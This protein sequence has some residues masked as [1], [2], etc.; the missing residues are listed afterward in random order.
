MLDSCSCRLT[1]TV[2]EV[3]RLILHD[4]AYAR[5][6]SEQRLRVDALTRTLLRAFVAGLGAV[7]PA[8]PVRPAAVD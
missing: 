6:A 1:G 7:A 5:Q 4:C 2:D 3:A 8:G